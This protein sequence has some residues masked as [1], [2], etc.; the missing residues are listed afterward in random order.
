MTVH[1]ESNERGGR[2]APAK[3]VEQVRREVMVFILEEAGFAQV[4]TVNRDGFPVGRTMVAAIN[5]DWSVDLIQ[6]RVHRRLAQL[7]RNPRIE[8]TWAG[9]P[10]AGSVND[11]PHVYD[12]GLLVPRVVFLRGVAEFMD[13]D[14]T[15]ARYRR[16]T[17]IQRAK[18]LTRAPVRS[19]DNVRAEL[20][21]LH[22][23]PVQLRAEGFGAGAQSFTWSAGP[24]PGGGHNG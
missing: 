10:A 20:I 8:I 4:Y 13:D 19:A 12:W 7:R 5:D 11:R 2:G 1:V 15:V 21:G 24:V 16:Q 18:G 22:V 3:P 6:R 17:S 14:W 9:Q 23:R